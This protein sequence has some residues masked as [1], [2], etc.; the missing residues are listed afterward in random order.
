MA[1]DS[2]FEI[3]PPIHE[4]H[5][6]ANTTCVMTLK[7]EP[8][9]AVMDLVSTTATDLMD[10]I[11]DC[12]TT[13]GSNNAY[14]AGCLVLVLNPDHVRLLSSGGYDKARLRREIHQR[15]RVPFDKVASRG[16]VGIK[17]SA[18]PDGFHYVTR[19]PA[20]VE[21]VVAGGEG[22]HSGVILP[23]ALRSEPVYEAVRLADG[24]A[25]TSIDAFLERT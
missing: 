1:E 23:W 6:D 15:A 12:C 25:A 5:F 13:L 14:V 21:I 9:H 20:D 4:E 3:W 2:R 10:T 24:S 22:G 16:I 19:S 18:A 11:V 7:A 17:P 8:P